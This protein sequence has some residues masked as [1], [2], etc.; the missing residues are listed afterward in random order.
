MFYRD[1]NM[2]HDIGHRD[3]ALGPGKSEA[4]DHLIQS[5]AMDER[6]VAG[7]TINSVPSVP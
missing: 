7:A 2:K 6:Q 4:L 3:V 1:M 5:S